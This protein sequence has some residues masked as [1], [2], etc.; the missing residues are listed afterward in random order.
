MSALNR[1]AARRLAKAV[2]VPDIAS[3]TSQTDTHQGT[4]QKRTPA[5]LPPAT[6]LPVESSK[7][8]KPR[9]QVGMPRI[10]PLV[11]QNP[12]IILTGGAQYMQNPNLPWFDPGKPHKESH[13]ND[14]AS[15][16]DYFGIDAA[17]GDNNS[18]FH[19]QI[20]MNSTHSHYQHKK[21]NQ[22]WNWAHN[23]I[24]SLIEPYLKLL[25]ET[26]CLRHPIPIPEMISCP[27]GGSAISL[28]VICVTWKGGRVFLHLLH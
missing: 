26:E 21:A 5:H 17:G 24:P 7:V 10:K 19:H 14:T 28:T 6:Y 23:T 13:Q 11:R 16:F 9:K 4:S 22:W 12:D 3:C 20:P 15:T 1:R 2:A 25:Q 8:P 18:N 27:C